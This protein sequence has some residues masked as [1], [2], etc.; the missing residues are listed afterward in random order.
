MAEFVLLRD[1]SPLI[2]GQESNHE[3]SAMF[4]LDEAEKSF[5]IPT[6]IRG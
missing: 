6:E 5:P 3:C 4:G 1:G 2:K